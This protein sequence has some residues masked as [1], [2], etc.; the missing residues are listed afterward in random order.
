MEKSC[1]SSD[2]EQHKLDCEGETPQRETDGVFNKK[3]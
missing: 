1:F 3:M 2:S